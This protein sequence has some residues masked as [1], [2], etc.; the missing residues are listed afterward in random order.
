M[1]TTKRMSPASAMAIS[2]WASVLAVMTSSDTCLS[3]WPRPPVS[4]SSKRCP[5]CSASA[6]TRSRVT[7]TCSC[8]MEMRRPTIRLKRA[9]LPTLGRP[10]MATIRLVTWASIVGMVYT[11]GVVGT[12]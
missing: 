10:T 5:L 2:A 9:D 11:M 6:L 7:P 4:I 12:R 1:S 8:T 3:K